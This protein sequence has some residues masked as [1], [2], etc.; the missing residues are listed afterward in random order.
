[1]HKGI[2]TQFINSSSNQH[3]NGGT[4]SVSCRKNMKSLHV[5]SAETRHVYVFVSNLFMEGKLK[6]FSTF[7]V[8][9]YFRKASASHIGH[10][11]VT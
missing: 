10:L 11:K 6:V 2:G 4:Q 8:Q 1:M 3:P 7:S 5:Y 9:R